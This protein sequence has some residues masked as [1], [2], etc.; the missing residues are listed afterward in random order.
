VN[1]KSPFVMLFFI[2]LYWF[3]TQKYGKQHFE[4]TA[5]CGYLDENIELFDAFKQLGL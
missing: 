5:Y 3:F 2:V 4:N 1:R